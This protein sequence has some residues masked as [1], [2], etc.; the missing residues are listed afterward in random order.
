MTVRH[1]A[2]AL[3]GRAEFSSTQ[4]YQAASTCPAPCGPNC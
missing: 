1:E 3:R 2:G 4:I